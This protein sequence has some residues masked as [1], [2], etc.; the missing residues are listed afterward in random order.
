MCM[1]VGVYVCRRRVR[2]RYVS[3]YVRRC[4]CVQV[5]CPYV[6]CVSVCPYLICVSVCPMSRRVTQ[7]R[8]SRKLLA[9]QGDD[10]YFYDFKNAV[11][12]P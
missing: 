5:S 2:I 7:G 4:V 1:C 9:A 3:V 8:P 6:I 12:Y 10:D 11:E